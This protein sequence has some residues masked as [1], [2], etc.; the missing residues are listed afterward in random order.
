MDRLGEADV[1]TDWFGAIR[2]SSAK[3]E[4]MRQDHAIAAAIKEVGERMSYNDLCASGLYDLYMGWTPRQWKAAEKWVLG[5]FPAGT[6]AVPSVELKAVWSKAHPNLYAP[7]LP[8]AYRIT[9][10]TKGG[11]VEDKYVDEYALDTRGLKFRDPV[12]K[13]QYAYP[14]D[15][16][17]EVQVTENKA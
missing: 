10:W 15:V 12:T 1:K 14:I 17:R 2:H 8:S 7:K 13:V 6:Y 4:K 11:S 5:I 16:F 3:A 9:L